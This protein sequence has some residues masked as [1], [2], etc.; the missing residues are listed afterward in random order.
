MGELVMEATLEQMLELGVYEQVPTDD[1]IEYTV[2][3]EKARE[4]AP[5]IYFAELDAVDAAV[6]EAIEL[7][8]LE[9]DFTIDPEGNLFTSYVVTE[10]GSLVE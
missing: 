3:M 4:H 10:K 5:T 1:G 8:Y 6:L 2:N 7:G 9:L